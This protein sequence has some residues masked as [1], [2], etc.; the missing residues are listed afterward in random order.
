MKPEKMKMFGKSLYWILG[1]KFKWASSLQISSTVRGVPT[2]RRDIRDSPPDE[3]NL[4]TSLA[5]DGTQRL[6]FDIDDEEIYLRESS[7]PG[8]YHLIFPNPIAGDDYDELM[9][10]LH[11]AGIVKD[12]NYAS[13]ESLGYFTLRTPWTT[14]DDED[15]IDTPPWVDLPDS[16]DPPF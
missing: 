8:H 3:A 4:I 5:H 1:Q 16:D 2:K 11:Q 7:T 13:Y 12:G 10:I 14:K 6:M 9:R 15:S